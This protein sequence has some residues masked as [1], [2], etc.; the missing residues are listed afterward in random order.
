[1]FGKLGKALKS[2][3]DKLASAVFVDKKLIDSIVKDLKKALIEADIN[4]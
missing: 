2:A 3:T 1:M 4:I